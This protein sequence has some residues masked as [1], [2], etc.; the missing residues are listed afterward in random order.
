M[1]LLC[2]HVCILELNLTNFIIE[3]VFLSFVDCDMVIRFCPNLTL[4]A[5]LTSESPE[6][7][8]DVNE[9]EDITDEDMESEVDSDEGEEDV[10]E[11]TVKDSTL[12]ED[13]E[14]EEE[15]VDEEWYDFRYELEEEEDKVKD[16]QMP[17]NDL[18]IGPEDGK[19]PFNHDVNVHSTEG[20]A[21]L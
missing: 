12:S 18:D 13:D 10:E 7:E 20:Y 15:E 17:D 8:V 1:A 6:S 5:H 9:E 14:S 16:A 3:F 11:S 2:E 21:L 4:G 19:E